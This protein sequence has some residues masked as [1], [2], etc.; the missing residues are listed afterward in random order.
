MS[1]KRKVPSLVLFLCAVVGTS[2]SLYFLFDNF[3]KNT[4]EEIVKAWYY[5]EIVNLQE[6]QILSAI[7]KNQNLFSRSPYIRAVVLIDRKDPDRPLFSVGE[8]SVGDLSSRIEAAENEKASIISFRLGF[9]SRNVLVKLPNSSDLFIIYEVSSSLLVWSY[10]L[11]V[12][13]GILSALYLI[14]FAFRVARRDERRKEEIRLD[15]TKRLS[16]DLNSPLLTLS[17]ISMQIK[18]RDLQA[19]HKLEAVSANIRRLFAQSVK[20]EERL[21]RNEEV[22]AVAIDAEKS[23]V[24]IAAVLSEL[25]L[26][27]RSEF[28]LLAGVELNLDIK[29]PAESAFAE[30]SHEEFVRH[31]HNLL[32]NSL[33]ATSGLPNG[34]VDVCLSVVDKLKQVKLTIADNGCGIPE[35]ILPRLGV[36]D[37]SHGKKDGKGLGL[38]FAME[39]VKLWNG[40]LNLNSKVGQGTRIE[41]E[42]PQAP[43]PEWFCKEIV[44]GPHTKVVIVD[45]DPSIP[46]L[47]KNVL[48]LEENK[49]LYF[50]SS[51]KF[52]K[53]FTKDGQLEES[54]LFLFDYQIDD[55]GDGLSLIEEFGL[56][57]ESV[58]VTSAYGDPDL[59]GRVAQ[60]KAPCIK[61]LPKILMARLGI[62]KLL[63]SRHSNGTESSTIWSPL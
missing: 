49:Y 16:H 53:W 19:H 55:N 27:K 13:L 46:I 50:D 58:L 63:N 31:I 24:P 60:L 20:L 37:F 47:W 38:H 32:Q 7:S 18:K 11:A 21:A 14:I 5:G 39:A 12:A 57:R 62:R 9:L 4:S 56:E 17:S 34:K 59:L 43:T 36:K 29:H 1:L 3:L 33:E 61:L 8:L 40:T 10:F 6:G 45:D 22:N 23:P 28:S 41:I 52:K 35:N 51:A 30:L 25:I 42:L 44:I 26:H 15:I 2:G 54:L 48:C